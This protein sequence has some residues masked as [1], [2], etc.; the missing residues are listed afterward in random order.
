MLFKIF[1]S[2]DE[3]AEAFLP[4]FYLPKTE[5]AKRHFADAINNP[6]TQLYL[7]PGD[8]SLYCL[9]IFDDESGEIQYD[10]KILGN[11]IDFKNR[12]TEQPQLQAVES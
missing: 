8:Y 5:A 12:D 6:E 1:S 4:P 11:G 3:K 2:Y 10:K 7:H 9:G